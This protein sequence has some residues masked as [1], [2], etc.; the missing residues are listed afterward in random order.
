MLLILLSLIVGVFASNN[1]KCNDFV[2]KCGVFC[3]C[4]NYDCVVDCLWCLG[5]DWYECCNY[6]PSCYFMNVVINNTNIM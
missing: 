3:A 2:N 6:F 1:T 5:G 4:E